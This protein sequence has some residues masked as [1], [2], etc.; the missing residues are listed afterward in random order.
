MRWDGCSDIS[1]IPAKDGQSESN[2][3]E[4][5]D[6]PKLRDIVQNNWPVFFKTSRSKMTKKGWGLF[7]IEGD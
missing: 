6:K 1:D 2:R 4:K 3:E 5:L 7:Q